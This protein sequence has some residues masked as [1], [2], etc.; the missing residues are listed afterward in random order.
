MDRDREIERG[1]RLAADLFDIMPD[2]A[3]A[4]IQPIHEDIHD[5]TLVKAMLDGREA[6][7]GSRFSASGTA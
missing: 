4:R 1:T 2:Q 5:R 6:A 3:D 7:R